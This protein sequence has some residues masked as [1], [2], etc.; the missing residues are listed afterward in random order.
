MF[1]HFDLRFENRFTPVPDSVLHGALMS[2]EKMN[3]LDSR[4]QVV[5]D[6]RHSL[7][8]TNFLKLFSW[9]K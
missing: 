8:E 6:E 9:E 1:K 5:I 3:T 2:G 7:L 4:Q